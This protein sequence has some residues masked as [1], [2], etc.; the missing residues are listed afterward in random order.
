VDVRGLQLDRKYLKQIFGN[1]DIF[2]ES[3][4]FECFFRRD[5]CLKNEVSFNGLDTHLSSWSFLMESSDESMVN[6]SVCI[7]FSRGSLDFLDAQWE[8][9]IFGLINWGRG[10]G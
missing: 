1:F 10:L 2:E 4:N 8:F 9:F 5:F 6:L 3:Q 7:F